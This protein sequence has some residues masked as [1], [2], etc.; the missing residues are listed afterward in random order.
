MFRKGMVER[1]FELAS[2][3]RSLD[4]VRARLKEEGYS[5]IDLHFA[6]RSLRRDL[7]AKLIVGNNADA[8]THEALID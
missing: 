3:C 8:Q 2:Q 7:C 5:G 6:S 4:A 1:A